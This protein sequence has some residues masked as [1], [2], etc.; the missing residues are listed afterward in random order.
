MHA[1]HRQR[2]LNQTGTARF[3]KKPLEPLKELNPEAEGATREELIEDRKI[4]ELKTTPEEELRLKKIQKEA[5][6]KEELRVKQNQE[7]A[8][9]LEERRA[10]EKEPQE[11]AEQRATKAGGEA[12][13]SEKEAHAGRSEERGSG[14]R[15][16]ERSGEREVTKE[17]RPKWEHDEEIMEEGQPP[18]TEYESV[19]LVEL[20]KGPKRKSGASTQRLKLQGQ[21]FYKLAKRDIELP[22]ALPPPLVEMMD[23]QASGPAG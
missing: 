20:L 7:E 18:E 17:E 10:V 15:K 16:D 2:R 8:Q 14:P 12:F 6:W 19:E 1:H 22:D 13:K 4:E 21:G 3:Q 9:T 5:E 11:E 23:T